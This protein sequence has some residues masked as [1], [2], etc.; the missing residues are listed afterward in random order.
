MANTKSP[1]QP[2]KDA[3]ELRD[4][5]EREARL[6]AV[7]EQETPLTKILIGVNIVLW[8][9]A[10]FWGDMLGIRTQF[11]NNLQL[12]FYTGMKINARIADG[13]WWRLVSSQFVHLNFMHIAFNA[14]GLYV[15]GP[16]VER[17]YGW[18]R[19]MVL[20][21]V[22]GTGGALASFYFV[23]ANSGGASGAIYGLV[24]ALLV[25]GFKYRRELPERVSRAL[26]YGMLPWVVFSLGIGFL[27]AIPMDNAAHLGG[28]FTGGLMVLV[29]TS[30]LRPGKKT[31]LGDQVVWGLVIV[32][33]G[34]LLWTGAAWA[35][36]AL[37]CVM[38]GSAEY[39]ACYP[40]LKG[41]T[42]L[43]GG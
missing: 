14:Y 28:L 34:A 13:E 32:A 9:F 5:V 31:A 38:G 3:D 12:V 8:V 26:T 16:M 10:F 36:E 7:I 23:Q 24:G 1:I 41:L 6:R 20:Y 27:D 42:Q 19:F 2:P 4:I 35:G 25:F 18:R 40:E 21:L 29:L 43:S 17:F 37:D 30:K 22:S 39:F 33:I 11:Y 15:L